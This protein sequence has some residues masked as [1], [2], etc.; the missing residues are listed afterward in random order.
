MDMIILSAQELKNTSKSVQ[1]EILDIES[2]DE[3]SDDLKYRNLAY[4]NKRLIVTRSRKRAEKDRHDR[5]EAVAKLI[6][7]IGSSSNPES[8]ISNYGYKKYLNISGNS[9]V[10]INEEKIQT[11]ERWDGIHGIVTNI[12]DKSASENTISLQAFMAS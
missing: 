4:N 10:T 5:E 12:K 9:T 2:Y 8:L 1:K 3:I 11:A 6:K 7:K